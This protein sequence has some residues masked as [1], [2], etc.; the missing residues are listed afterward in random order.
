M[1]NRFL[2]LLR[3]HDVVERTLQAI[4]ASALIYTGCLLFFVLVTL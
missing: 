4:I 2:D 3:E 1:W